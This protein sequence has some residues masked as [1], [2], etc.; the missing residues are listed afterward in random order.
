MKTFRFISEDFLEASLSDQGLR[1]VAVLPLV[2]EVLGKG[3]KG[4]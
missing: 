1:D 4:K 3:S 2:S